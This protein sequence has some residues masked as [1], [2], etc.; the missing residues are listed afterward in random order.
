[1][2]FLITSHSFK[3]ESPPAFSLASAVVSVRSVFSLKLYF[4]IDLFG[5]FTVHSL[6]GGFNFYYGSNFKRCS[7]RLIPVLYVFG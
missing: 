1:M 2:K 7:R 5:G 4:R 6:Y 3:F